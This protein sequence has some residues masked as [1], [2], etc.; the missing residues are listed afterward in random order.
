METV[1]LSSECTE[2]EGRPIQ[3]IY[4]DKERGGSKR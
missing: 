3:L 1:E 2:D 4:V